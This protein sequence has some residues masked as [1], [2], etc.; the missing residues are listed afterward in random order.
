[1]ATKTFKYRLY[2][3]AAQRTAMQKVLDACRWVYNKTLELRRDAWKEQQQ[4]LS[5]YDTHKILTKWKKEQHW[6]N[7][8]YSQCLRE[9]QER[10]DLAFQ[11]FFRRVKAGQKPGY[12]RFK[13]DW[14]KSFTYTQSGFRLDGN[15]LFLSKIGNIKIVVH[16]AIEGK[17]KRVIVKCNHLGNW[18]A[19][20]LC[21]VDIKPLP[22]TNS[23]IGIDVGCEYFAT[24]SNGEQIPNPRFLRHGEKALEKPQVRLGKA[25]KGTPEHRKYKRVVQHIHERIANRRS[26]FAHKLSRMLVDEYQI[27]ALEDLKIK[28]MQDGNWRSLNKSIGD[29]AWYQLRT[30]IVYKAEWAGRNAVL[31]DPRNTSQMCSGCGEIVPKKLSERVHSCPHCGL[32]I[33]RDHNAALNILARG[34]SCLG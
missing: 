2:P 26:D 16:C 24:L 11:H 3:T 21:D 23:V 10:V 7:D 22:P 19:C 6:L 31:V 29:A 27:I 13:G 4:S 30:F 12:P 15:R 17:I 9:P 28:D 32:K 34:L 33:D 8:V 1:M 18:Y 20:F 25:T 14:Y 5:K